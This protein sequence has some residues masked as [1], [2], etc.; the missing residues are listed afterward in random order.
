MVIRIDREFLRDNYFRARANA[1]TC[2][3]LVLLLL[4]IV[5]CQSQKKKKN[6]KDQDFGPTV[7]VANEALRFF[8]SELVGD[9]VEIIGPDETVG[10]PASWNPDDESIARIQRADRI[11]TVGADY[12]TWPQF[13]S[14]DDDKIFEVSR[15]M[16]RDFIEV[17]GEIHKH[18]PDGEEHAHSGLANCFWLDPEL[19]KKFV[20]RMAEILEQDYP[21]WADQIAE[22]E[23][24]LSIKFDRLSEK[25]EQASP[26]FATV[27]SSDTR[28]QYLTRRLGIRDVY[29][30][31]TGH[32]KEDLPSKTWEE[33]D[34][35]QGVE[36]AS[37][38]LFP[39]EP[40]DSLKAELKKRQI[41][42]LVVDT[43]ETRGDGNNYF[44]RMEKVIDQLSIN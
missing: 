21:Q 10:H 34:R 6:G 5:G 11:F 43:L 39:F 18:G 27:Y 44:E 19:G 8:V 32:G 22:R 4:A 30:F 36:P 28:Y 37:V 20:Q 42:P 2:G 23:K 15:P 1:A 17:E 12:E 3:M 41:R 7:V 40:S 24:S 25:I 31:W 35:R 14:I 16:Y 29:F 38:M 33:L 13:V 9:Q 26:R